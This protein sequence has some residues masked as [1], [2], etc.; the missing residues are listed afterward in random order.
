V[1][2]ARDP[3]LYRSTDLEAYAREVH[4]SKS[5][6]ILLNKSDL[7]PDHVRKAWADHFDKV[8][9]HSLSSMSVIP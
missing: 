4:T 5:S 7:L 3:L 6:F 2:D 9:S 1:V 8:C